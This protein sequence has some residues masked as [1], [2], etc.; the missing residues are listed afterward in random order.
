MAGSG[1]CGWEPPVYWA[2]PDGSSVFT[3]SPGHYGNDLLYLSRDLNNKMKYGADQIM[4][5]ENN[6]EGSE[7][8]T[9]L[10]SSQDMLP[11]IDYSEFIDSWNSFDT[12]KDEKGDAKNVF[13]PN[14]E[15]MTVDEFM[16]LA[17]KNATK[18]DTI[19]GERPNVWVYIHGPGHHDALTASREAS[20]LLPAA[21]KF[22]SIANVIDAKLFHALSLGKL[23][24]M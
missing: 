19:M 24:Q 7:I 8:H 20:K 21:E 13:L 5:W 1:L 6:F 4:Y 23:S 22:L 16:P 11:A 15:L 2:S 18:V 12:L 9:P 10:L 17:E 14:M 3:Y